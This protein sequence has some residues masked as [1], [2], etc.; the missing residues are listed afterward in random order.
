M[1]PTL[2]HIGPIPIHSYGLMIAIGFL[3]AITVVK[4]LSE[5]SGINV[6]QIM[7]LSFWSLIVGFIGA[8]FLFIL[9]RWD[10]FAAD[11]VS[12]FKVW[13]G[14]LVFYGGPLAVV[15][16]ALYFMRKNQLPLWRTSDVL[17]PGLTIAHAFGRIGCIGAGCCYGRPTNENWGF[18]FNSDLVDESLRG[19]YLHPT[20]LYECVALVILFFGLL[21]T[22]RKKAFDGQVALVYFMAYPIIRSIIEIYRGDIIRGFVIPGILSTSQFISVLVFAVATGLLVYRLKRVNASGGPAAAKK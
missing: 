13:E 4:K 10:S 12:V 6:D 22:F 15:P 18:K 7:D 14:G 19:V 1:F 11:P 17:V 5:K 8:R 20:Q 3:V 16:F 21:A 2:F 9:T